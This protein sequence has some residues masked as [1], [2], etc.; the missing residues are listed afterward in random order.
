MRGRGWCE[1]VVLQ[2]LLFVDVLSLKPIGLPQRYN[3]QKPQ[4]VDNLCEDL[5]L[6]DDIEEIDETEYDDFFRKRKER[7]DRW[8]KALGKLD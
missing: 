5:S 6:F 4:I 3:W 7:E 1:V 2:I 8:A